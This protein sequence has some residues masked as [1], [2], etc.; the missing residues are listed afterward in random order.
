MATATTTPGDR[1]AHLRRRELTRRQ[2]RQ[3]HIETVL[4]I[5]PELEGECDLVDRGRNIGLDITAH[6]DVLRALLD[7]GARAPQAVVLSTLVPVG[8]AVRLTT[9]LRAEFA[10]PILLALGPADGQ[11]AAPV[12]A[13]GGRPVLSRPLVADELLAAL[14][15]CSPGR[16]T[17]PD[18]VEVG[19]LLLDPESHT[20]LLNGQHLDLTARQFSVLLHLAARVDEVVPQDELLREVWPGQDVTAGTLATAVGRVRRRLAEAGVADAILTLRGFGY[21]LDP[22]VMGPA[23]GRRPT[24]A[25]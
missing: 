10:L 3:S 24:A 23:G 5:D 25:R 18:P 8:D 6:T 1:A 4:I 2:L 14:R 20:G 9:L 13:A 22:A 7:I 19:A 11:L 12:I 17:R 16:R 21:R 15:A